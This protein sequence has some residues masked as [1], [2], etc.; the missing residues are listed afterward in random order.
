V[1]NT[2][3]ERLFKL[4]IDSPASLEMTIHRQNRE[5]KV[6]VSDTTKAK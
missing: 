4:H 5:V 1:K 2:E 6:Q 3:E